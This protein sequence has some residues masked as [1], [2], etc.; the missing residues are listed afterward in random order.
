MNI[1]SSLLSKV[2]DSNSFYTMNRYNITESDFFLQ[3]D[4]YRFIKDYVD[5]Y[6]ECPSYTAV[7]AECKEF[8][9][10][11]EVS[12]NIE[13]LCRKVKSDRAKRES[14]ELLQNEATK[15]FSELPGDKFIQWLKGNTD[16]I[17]DTTQTVSS[18]GSNWATNGQERREMY[19][20]VKNNKSNVLVPTPFES[21]NE[22]LGGGFFAG[23]YVLLEAYTNKGKS[24]IAS[25]M[26]VTA[27]TE[28]Y[29]VL[30]YSPELSQYNQQQRLDTLLGHFNNMAMRNGDLYEENEKL[31][32]DYL[33]AFNEN[34]GNAPY[35][36]KTMEDLSR[37]LTVDVIESDLQENSNI[38][39]V[40]IDGFNLM[41]HGRGSK[42][43]DNMTVTSR[44][45]RQICGKYNVVLIVVHQVSTQGYKDS[46]VPGDDDD[47]KPL[48]PPDLTAYSETAAVI[49]DACTVITYDYC[50]GDGA[51]RV[52]KSRANNVDQRI[53]LEVNY[54]Q[55][56]ITEVNNSVF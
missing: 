30:H 32:F 56:Y 3:K 34:T 18:S 38:K 51:L 27:W 49:Q 10:D 21:L 25:D 55:G 9:Y 14:F 6:H 35:I 52:V 4:T 16:R 42:L 54:N 8:E 1:E 47:F 39:M 17:Y 29:G 24:W 12:D 46:Q 53:D 44:R 26:G 36:V 22:G 31:Y 40:I 13:Y 7:V 37:G 5:T 45:L 48:N 20:D 19:L 11:P 23:D 2:I 33:S 50:D 43:R 15:K 28:G 41:N